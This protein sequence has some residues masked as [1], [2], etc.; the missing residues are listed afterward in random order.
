MQFIPTTFKSAIRELNTKELQDRVMGQ[1]IACLD[2]KHADIEGKEL[3]C[4]IRKDRCEYISF[5]SG[6]CN[7]MCQAYE[8]YPFAFRYKLNINN[9]L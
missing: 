5:D 6:M 8:E 3:Y 4:K 1:Y 7:E 2:C 9:Y